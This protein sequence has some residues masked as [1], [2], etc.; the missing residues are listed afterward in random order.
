MAKPVCQKYQFLTKS[1]GSQ[2]LPFDQPSCKDEENP[3]DYNAGGYL[4]VKVNDTFKDG[5][6]TVLRK[7]G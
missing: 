6:Y 3:A 5:R 1:K 4:P 7:L 2:I